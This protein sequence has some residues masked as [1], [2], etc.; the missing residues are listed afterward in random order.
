MQSGFLEV[1]PNF[2]KQIGHVRSSA[3]IFDTGML[4]SFRVRT[5][6]NIEDL[7]VLL[8]AFGVAMALETLLDLR[9]FMLPDVGM[10]S[11]CMKH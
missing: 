9:I 4:M 6:Q 2:S 7:P 5:K 3:S 11:G 8:F 1:S 10:A